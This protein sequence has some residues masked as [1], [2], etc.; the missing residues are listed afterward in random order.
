[1]D[2]PQQHEIMSSLEKSMQEEESMAYWYK[3]YASLI[4]DN[5]WPLFEIELRV[6]LQRPS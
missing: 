4:I 5:L 6:L 2:M 1:M 3:I